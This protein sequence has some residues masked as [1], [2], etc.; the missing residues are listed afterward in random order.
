MEVKRHISNFAKLRDLGGYSA[1]YNLDLMVCIDLN[2]DAVTFV[3]GLYKEFDDESMKTVF[4]Y[5][6]S[7]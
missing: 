3:G 2:R 5:L 1:I 6:D 7:K 4:L